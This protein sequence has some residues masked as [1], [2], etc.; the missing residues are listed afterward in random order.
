VFSG[1]VWG[2]WRDLKTFRWGGGYIRLVVLEEE[3]RVRLAPI[4]M[5]WD[6]P[7]RPI[8]EDGYHQQNHEKKI[9]FRPPPN[10]SHTHLIAQRTIA[11]H[12]DVTSH[13]L[14]KHFYLQRIGDDFLGLTINVGVNER[15]V[16]VA[17]VK[18]GRRGGSSSA[19]RGAVFAGPAG[20]LTG[21][22]VTE[23]G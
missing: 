9:P 3:T 4:S 13:R 7:D 11:S 14:S 5:F 23:S 10:R 1:A 16:V 6:V 20:E 12:E 22:D 21:N 17:C 19:N 18:R 15:D 2:L 8:V